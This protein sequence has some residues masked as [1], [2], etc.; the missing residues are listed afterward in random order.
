M[1]EGL[2]D[3]TATLYDLRLQVRAD[4]E[5]VCCSHAEHILVSFGESGKPKCRSSH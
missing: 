3:T 2:T 5:A 1:A 4:A